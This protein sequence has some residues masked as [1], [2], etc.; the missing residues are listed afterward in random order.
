MRYLIKYSYRKYDQI[1]T[2]EYITDNPRPFI[3]RMITWYG[4]NVH[5][6]TV[7]VWGQK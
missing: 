2:G 4:P 7:A 1:H 3:Q 5:F 6:K